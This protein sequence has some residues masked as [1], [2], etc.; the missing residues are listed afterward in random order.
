MITKLVRFKKPLVVNN[1]FIILIIIFLYLLEILRYPPDIRPHYP[2][3]NVLFYQGVSESDC[4][5]TCASPHCT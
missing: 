4:V 1:N 5:A 3:L 2:P